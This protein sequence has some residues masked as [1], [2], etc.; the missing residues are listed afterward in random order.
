MYVNKWPLFPS[1]PL[2]IK[3][4]GFVQGLS[5]LHYI[6]P[7]QAKIAKFS[8]FSQFAPKILEPIQ[9]CYELFQTLLSTIWMSDIIVLHYPKPLVE[10]TS[11]NLPSFTVGWPKSMGVSFSIDESKTEMVPN[12]N[13]LEKMNS[14]FQKFLWFFPTSCFPIAKFLSRTPPFS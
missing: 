9:K 8:R 14:L 13:A 7:H 10:G 11:R 6:G 3:F 5:S 2:N 1:K 4:I 12:K